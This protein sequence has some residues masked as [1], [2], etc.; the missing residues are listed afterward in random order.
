MET[1]NGT[2]LDIS[3]QGLCF[4]SDFP[5]LMDDERL[6]ELT[7]SRDEYTAQFK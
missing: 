5:Y 2:F 7:L 1:L 6:Y 3:E 4:V